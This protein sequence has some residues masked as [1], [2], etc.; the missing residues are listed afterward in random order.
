MANM[1]YTKYAQDMETNASVADWT[2][3]TIMASL[4]RSADYT[5]DIDNDETFSDIP[6]GAVVATASLGFGSQVGATIDMDDV[7][8]PAV[9]AGDPIDVV[10]IHVDGGDLL[11]YLDDFGSG[12]PVTPDDGDINGVVDAGGLFSIGSEV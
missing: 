11:F 4:V 6:G 3:D 2:S 8:W 5:V 1:I 12:M 10:V 7:T 9:A